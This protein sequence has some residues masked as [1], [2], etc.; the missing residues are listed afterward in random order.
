MQKVTGIGGVFLKSADAKALA[1]WYDKHLG[2][3]F[4]D[5]L[6]VSFK[7]INDDN[8]QVPGNTVFSLF[9]KDSKY[10]DPSTSPFMIN[11]RVKDLGALLEQ[12]KKDGVEVVG[13]A[14]EEDY[15]KFGWILDLDGNK[16]ELWEPVDE[17][18]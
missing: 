16:I 11:L 12:L 10:F 1:A 3:T 15:G 5:N 17:K 14:Q 13:E 2:F 4:G 8:P 9:K 7:W 18:L 6:Y